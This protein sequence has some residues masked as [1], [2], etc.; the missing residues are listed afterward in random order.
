MQ[1]CF[2]EHPE[3]YGK[4]LEED[5]EPGDAPEGE[6]VALSTAPTS[7]NSSASSET[8]SQLPEAGMTASSTSSAEEDAT[9]RAQEAKAQV[10]SAHPEPRS[11]SDELVPKAAHDATDAIVGKSS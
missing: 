1:D 10:E 7:S 5:E 11:E 9:K 4:E 6:Q 2:R 3:I 8:P